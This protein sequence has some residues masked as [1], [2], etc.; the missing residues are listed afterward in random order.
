MYT[1]DIGGT[2]ACV[3]RCVTEA[4]NFKHHSDINI[5]DNDDTP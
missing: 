5:E 4:E 1:K 2:A 3:T